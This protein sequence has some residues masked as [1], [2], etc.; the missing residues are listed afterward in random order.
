MR[1]TPATGTAMQHQQQPNG[2]LTTTN[3]Q[4]GHGNSS[5]NRAG[6]LSRLDLLKRRHQQQQQQQQATTSTTQL[7]RNLS[8]LNYYPIVTRPPSVQPTSLANGFGPKA[9]LANQQIY[10]PASIA[11]PREFN[12]N[13]ST[14]RRNVAAADHSAGVQHYAATSV[15][16][17]AP[18]AR[19]S[20]SLR[21]QAPQQRPESA[22]GQLLERFGTFRRK[23]RRRL[24][25]GRSWSSS[26]RSQH[27]QEQIYAAA[28]IA[29][30][31][32]TT[33]TTWQG[34]A[35]ST[36]YSKK[37]STKH[38]KSSIPVAPLAP[39]QPLVLDPELYAG[40]PVEPEA[41]YAE[42]SHALD[43]N[44]ERRLLEH[45][46]EPELMAE[47]EARSLVEE[48]SKRQLD[49]VQLVSLLRGW[50]NDELAEQ[51]IVVR[52]LQEDLYDGQV[53]C[54]MLEK[55]HRIHLDVVEVTQN[56][57]A[58]RQKL[59]RVLET[60]NRILALQA[61]NWARIRWSVEGIHSKDPIEILHLLI[62]MAL[63]YR[64][65]LRLPANVQ[66]QVLVFQKHQNEL[67]R[68]SHLV[69]LTDEFVTN[70]LEQLSG[71]AGENAAQKPNANRE[72]F[73]LLIEC[74]PEKLPIVER[75]LIK[76]CQRHLNKINMSCLVGG[77]SQLD[78]ERLDPA[79]FSD[80]LL[81]VFLIASLEE[82]FVPL[83]NLF[84]TS[85]PTRATT[86]GRCDSPS[87]PF[88]DA[89]NNNIDSPIEQPTALEP[90]SYINCQPIE[91]LHNV[92]VA[93]QLMEEAGLTDIR[94]RVR[95]EEI[96]NGDL[97]AVLRV[98]YSLFSRY[99]HL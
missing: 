73:D 8:S 92:N 72:P 97:R 7:K 35:T 13:Y 33:A 57:E 59:G 9:P 74:A 38:D 39:S 80:G 16:G 81:L 24:S 71:Q 89:N 62:T 22:L 20:H 43:S 70:A 86:L 21:E 63:F 48:Q 28:S 2:V 27:P 51:R 15:H 94:K 40:G 5:T 23:A 95:A 34:R 79:Q 55:L 3:M 58:Q 90:S 14:M 68:R 32:T 60:L 93:L 88:I 76:F 91:K 1:P 12:A 52:D 6:T 29:G 96:V 11:S 46:L 44:A 87:L 53:L 77:A 85:L 26:R 19:V 69:Q 45:E 41:I 42:G 99:K 64:A 65:P 56:E 47:G 67:V 83:G 25:L 18:Q 36:I 61:R 54:K 4:N 84:T 75:S 30:Y 66:V 82:F 98:L 10:A 17:G 31:P 49:Y 78:H 50:I 37:Q